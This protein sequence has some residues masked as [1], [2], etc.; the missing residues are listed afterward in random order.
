[1]KSLD[2]ISKEKAESL[3]DCSLEYAIW[4]T[5][6]PLY[7]LLESNEEDTLKRDDII[8]DYNLGDK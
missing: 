3:K 8:K 7:C 5:L 6:L 1:M 4:T 2:R